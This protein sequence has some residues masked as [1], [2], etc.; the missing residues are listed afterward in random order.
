TAIPTETTVTTESFTELSG[1]SESLTDIETTVTSVSDGEMSPQPQ[2]TTH[3]NPEN[4][5]TSETAETTI[6]SESDTMH[7]TETNTSDNSTQK[8]V[9][10]GIFGI[11]GGNKVDVLYDLTW[12]LAAVI[13]AVAVPLLV[14]ARRNIII[15]KRRR[16]KGSSGAIEDYRR[17]MLLMK[18]MKMPEQG[19][20]NY[21]EYA[22]ELSARS[23]LIDS[24]TAE[25][26]I[27]TS[28]KASFGGESLTADE[29][30]EL[31]IAVNSLVKRYYIGLSRFGRFKLK[32]IYCII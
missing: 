27:N 18:L 20:M 29:A 30:H 4:A 2:E 3:I 31:R 28:L 13:I 21:S 9:G 14:I 1:T 15:T 6:P 19:E 26:I 7:E 8:S 25:V 32:Y 23:K 12:V 5:E 22:K 17:F 16:T 24:E 11:K 10:F